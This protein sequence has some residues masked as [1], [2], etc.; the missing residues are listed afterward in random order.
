MHRA[1]IFL[2]C[3]TKAQAEYFAR[4]AGVARLAYNWALA[5]WKRQAMEWWWSGKVTPFPTAFSL[6]KQF[7][8]IKRDTW[9]WITEISARVPEHAIFSVG[10]AYDIYKSG[11]S[12]YP[13]FKAKGKSKDAFLAAAN[14]TEVRIEG[15]RITIPKIGTIRLGRECRWPSAKAIKAVVS[16]KAGKWYVAVGFELPDQEIPARPNQAAGIDLGIKTPIKIVSGD[17]STDIGSGLAERLNVERR[18]LRRAHKTL[19]RRINGSGRY[20]RARARVARVQ[21]RIADIRSDFQH[22]ATSKIANMAERVGV[23]TLN[24][25]GML[26]NG[27]LARAI[28]DVGF[29]EIRRQL[30]YKAN[31]LIEADRFYPSSKTCSCCGSVKEKLTLS[32]RTFSCEDCGFVCDRDENAARNLERMAAN[33]AVTARGDGSSV[34][35][36]KLTLRSLSKKREAAK[37]GGL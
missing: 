3:P 4:A 28:A 36:R 8:A 21:K 1:Q 25:K 22:K 34:R 20:R 19:H 5:E 32:D 30:G 24:V 27:R 11:Q 17:V 31:A 12:R 14:T 23:E 7:N 10:Q 18:R 16:R 26:R 33:R 15:R 2:L 37:G 13:K 9:P 29:Y 6:Q 35:R